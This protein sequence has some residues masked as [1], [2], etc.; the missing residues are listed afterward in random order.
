MELGT[1][2]L[3]DIEVIRYVLLH[4]L[5]SQQHF[6]TVFSPVNESLDVIVEYV[7]HD[8]RTQSRY[9]AQSIG[10][11]DCVL[12]SKLLNYLLFT[13]AKFAVLAWVDFSQTIQTTHYFLNLLFLK[14]NPG[15]LR[16]S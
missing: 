10:N 4:P 14:F 2:S 16:P 9:L 5:A 1:K 3:L 12:V 11:V 7:F 13:G 6:P 15:F 8:I